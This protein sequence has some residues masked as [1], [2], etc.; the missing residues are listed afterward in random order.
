MSIQFK[1]IKKHLELHDII[2]FGTHFGKTIS[3]MLE[4]EP[5]YLLWASKQPNLLF[6][7]EPAALKL[8]EKAIRAKLEK[9][10][11]K[12]KTQVYMPGDQDDWWDDVPF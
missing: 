11:H 9:Q 3:Y 6:L 4:F 10:K 7:C 1:R 5:E 8:E 12:A 2:T